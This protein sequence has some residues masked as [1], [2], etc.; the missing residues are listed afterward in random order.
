[1]LILG[2][3]FYL[4]KEKKKVCDIFNFSFNMFSSGGLLI[5]F[6]V[7]ILG[8]YCSPLGSP[9][10]IEED[11]SSSKDFIHIIKFDI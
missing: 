10:N 3:I 8:C 11:E 7:L 9:D 2:L 1:M 5:F 6:A 4:T